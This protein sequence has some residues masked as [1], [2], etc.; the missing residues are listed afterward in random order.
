[1]SARALDETF[2]LLDE[3]DPERR[4]PVIASHAGYRFGHQD[5][6]LDART[7]ERVAERDGVIGVI[8]SEHQGADG[9]R[10]LPT[11]RFQHSLGVVFNH[12]EQIH[13]ITGSHR[14]SA[15]GSD[16][17]GFIKPTLAGLEDAGDLGRLEGAL[18]GRYGQS[19]AALI[20]S[21]NVLRLLRQYWRGGEGDA[22]PAPA[23]EETG[24]VQAT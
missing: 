3:I 6:N 14:H 16:H 9:L 22:G 21:D 23:V 18:R 12:L 1:M 24:A 10:L 17:D 7:I 13:E 19:D 11:A 20:A 5:Y 2:S 8:L 4:V 15:I